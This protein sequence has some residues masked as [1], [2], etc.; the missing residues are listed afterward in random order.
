M[1]SNGHVHQLFQ[2][3]LK[4]ISPPDTGERMKR[5]V[6]IEQAITMHNPDACEAADILAAIT[7]SLQRR[8]GEDALEVALYA[9]HLSQAL[10]RLDTGYQV[11]P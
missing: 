3:I 4:R 11:K 7:V 5:Q 1:G 10:D 8:F 2:D 9:S 6:A